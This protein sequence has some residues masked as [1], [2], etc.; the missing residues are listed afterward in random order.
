[1][2]FGGSKTKAEPQKITPESLQEQID[3]L[4]RRVRQCGFGLFLLGTI[5]LLAALLGYGLWI[6]SAN[7]DQNTNYRSLR[8]S[9]L[10]TEANVM[11]IFIEL[12]GNI[13]VLQAGNF[14]WVMAGIFSEYACVEPLS[15]TSQAETPI[16]GTYELQNVQLGALNFTVLVLNPPDMPLVQ[17]YANDDPFHMHICLINFSPSIA[18][19]STLG[20]NGPRIMEFTHNNVGRLSVD[21]NC[22]ASSTCEILPYLAE[23]YTGTDAY[24]I[25]DTQPAPPTS[26]EEFFVQWYYRQTTGNPFNLGDS[27]T[28]IE[29]L[30]LVLLSS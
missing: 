8:Q 20:V 9:V 14:N 22:Y 25:H 16:P 13:T 19:L 23:Q 2:F 21:P 30:Q 15:Y 1:M 29:P 6:R 4:K 11:Q 28:L 12:N 3:R 10:M 17:S 18:P 24:S 26:A 27:F 7:S 5:G